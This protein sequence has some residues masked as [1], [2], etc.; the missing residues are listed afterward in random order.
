MAGELEHLFAQNPLSNPNLGFSKSVHW[1]KVRFRQSTDQDLVLSI[2]HPSLDKVA[3]YYQKDDQW[4]SLQN[5]HEMSHKVRPLPDVSIS[6]PIQGSIANQSVY[7]KIESAGSISLPIKLRVREQFYGYMIT[8]NIALGVFFGLMLVMVLY[9]LL[10]YFSLRE[11][12]YLFYVGATFFGLLTSIVLNGYGYFFL[13]P[14]NPVLDQHLY[15]T[16]AGLSM[17]CS[18]R[19]A[20]EYL[21]LMVYQ[22]NAN[23]LMWFICFGSALMS[24]LS[25]IYTADQLLTLA[26]LLVLFTFPAYL[27][28]G[29]ISM[30]RGYKPAKFYVIAWIPY[31]LGLVVTTLR[32]AGLMPE[33]VFTAYGI[34]IGGGLE[35]VLLSLGL[36]YRIKDLRLRIANQELEKEQIKI[37]ALEESKVFLENEVEERT[38]ALKAANESK[39][40]FFSNIS[41]EFRTPLTLINGLA[42]KLRQKYSQD[43]EP[44]VIRRNGEQLLSL[45]NQLLE[46]TKFESGVSDLKK[47]NV[48][49][50]AFC[51]FYIQSYQSLAK[52]KGI[53][54]R[55]EAEEGPSIIQADEKA[56]NHIVQNLLS[57][58]L[59]FT[60][61]GEV[62][63]KIANEG[64]GQ[65]KL[66]VSDTGIGIA[67]EELPYIFDRFY[68]VDSSQ[69][70]AYDGT[71]IGLALV[72]ELVERT[73]ARIEVESQLQHGT[74]FNIYWKRGENVDLQQVSVPVL[75]HVESWVNA[76]Q[77]EAMNSGAPTILVVEDNPDMQRYIA[78]ILKISGYQIIQCIDGAEGLER[79]TELVPDFIIT[80]WMMP[81]M[82]GPELIN[83]LKSRQITSHIPVM[84]LTA[85]ADDQS[86]LSGLKVGAQAYL[87]KPFDVEALR[88]QVKN[89]VEVKIQLQNR[90]KANETTEGLGKEND[91]LKQVRAYLQT[92]M[93]MTEIEGNSLAAHFNYSRSQ[94]A[95]KLKALTDQSINE[96]IYQVKL[97]EAEK[98]LS[99]TDLNVSEIAYQT[100]FNSPAHFTKRF[101]QAHG[102]SP[103]KYRAQLSA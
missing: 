53:A 88:Y 3:F 26:R 42:E 73:G 82:S 16:F 33:S 97:Q 100:G 43:E 12:V 32:G 101:G 40:R 50:K 49:L 13:W 70:R 10:I 31:V 21:S 24:A 74:T 45:V 5:G 39:D 18:S 94:F 28:V 30:S 65:V 8:R 15:I 68:Q 78:D 48:D 72:Y 98:L 92:Q 9:N 102:I 84:L 58:A 11:R 69:T 46:L 71:G 103:T 87:T 81:K 56:L 76:E 47:Q 36:A 17:V 44:Q 57:N 96:F 34:E 63:M 86:K 23:K 20:A 6:F 95:K 75:P 90:L 89:L 83:E 35:A 52:D 66:T 38:K 51:H 14:S 79:A 67:K 64:D 37:S 1:V 62:M 80:D 85:R 55:L 93:A 41:H 60:E 7:L 2:E 59:K 22:P 77:T 4:T 99:T 27:V 91:F 29:F 61:S 25:L 54:L 19:F